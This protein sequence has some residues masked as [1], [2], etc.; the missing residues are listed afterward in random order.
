MNIIK[1]LTDY[2]QLKNFKLSAVR[3]QP[4]MDKMD[5]DDNYLYTKKGETNKKNIKRE[6]EK[7]V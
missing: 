4:S 5:K 1:T 2:S 3:L 7:Y 6:T